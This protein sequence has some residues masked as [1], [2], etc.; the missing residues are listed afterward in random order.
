MSKAYPWVSRLA[1]SLA[2][3]AASVLS[4]NQA[5][6]GGL[7]LFDRGARALGRGGAF[8]AGVDDPSALWYNPAGLLASKNQLVADAV[9]P[10]LLADYTP[11]DSMGNVTGQKV[12]AKPTPLPIP[13]LA[14]SQLVGKKLAWG[15]GIL[16]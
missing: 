6:A 4:A 8:V 3:L 2:V 15:A 10:I 16:A 12:S 5:H 13:T 1:L 14:I 11:Q 9:L 7:Y